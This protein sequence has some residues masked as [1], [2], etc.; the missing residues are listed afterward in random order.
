MVKLKQIDLPSVDFEQA[1]AMAR[2]AL[3]AVREGK[4]GYAIIVGAKASN[5]RVFFQS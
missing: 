3:E 4:P 1:K 2:S 5:L